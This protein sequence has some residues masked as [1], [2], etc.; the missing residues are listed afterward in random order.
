MCYWYEVMS[1]ALVVCFYF[2]HCLSKKTQCFSVLLL[3]HEK[4][5]ICLW[6]EAVDF[7]SL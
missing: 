5:L 1:W 4:F 2:D 7:M 6:I 3:N